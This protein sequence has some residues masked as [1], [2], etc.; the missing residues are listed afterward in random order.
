MCWFLVDLIRSDLREFPCLKT[1]CCES[2][3]EATSS[4]ESDCVF[5]YAESLCCPMPIDNHLIS[6]IGVI[7]RL[8]FMNTYHTCYLWWSGEPIIRM[9]SSMHYNKII[10]FDNMWESPK[11]I[12]MFMKV[13]CYTSIFRNLLLDPIPPTL[14]ESLEG[15]YM[16]NIKECK[17]FMITLHTISIPSIADIFD[18]VM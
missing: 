5:S 16:C 4:I 3:T 15:I 11:P 10:S 7:P 1:V 18:N 12:T 6:C 9:E 14:R 13:S 17:V 8:S 2:S